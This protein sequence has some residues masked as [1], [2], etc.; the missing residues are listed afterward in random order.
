MNKDNVAKIQEMWKDYPNVQKWIE[1]ISNPN[2]HIKMVKENTFFVDNDYV[3]AVESLSYLLT[4]NEIV[5][6]NPVNISKN[7]K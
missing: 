5:V 6:K 1:T 3:I 4:G 2:K 7:N